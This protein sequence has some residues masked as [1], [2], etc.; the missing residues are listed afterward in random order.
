MNAL[1]RLALVKVAM[2]WVNTGIPA[3]QF[4]NFIEH[5]K[6][7]ASQFR[8]HLVRHGLGA[9]SASNPATRTPE[10][11]AAL[12]YLLRQTDPEI[13]KNMPTNPALQ[14]LLGVLGDMVPSGNR[15][16]HRAQNAIHEF[17]RV[18]LRRVLNSLSR[19]NLSIMGTGRSTPQTLEQLETVGQATLHHMPEGSRASALELRRFLPQLIRDAERIRA[20]GPV[21]T[22]QTVVVPRPRGFRPRE[23][24]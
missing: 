10:A 15:E 7:P 16:G 5:L 13:A 8:P 24:R 20:A 14:R 23:V 4:F 11:Y 2:P 21:L 18:G 6:S 17:P 9:A 1:S 22:P 3:A 12:S 19:D